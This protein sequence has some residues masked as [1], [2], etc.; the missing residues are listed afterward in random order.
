MA[1]GK[2]RCCGPESPAIAHNELAASARFVTF[3]VRIEISQ[4]IAR[5]CVGNFCV[6]QKEN[7]RAWRSGALP[8]TTT[9]LT[10]SI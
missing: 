8:E 6:D 3:D 10:A 1:S 5:R 2:S 4:G 7:L 9:P